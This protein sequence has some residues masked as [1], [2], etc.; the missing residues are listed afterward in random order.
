MPERQILRAAVEAALGE[1]LPPDVDE[2]EFLLS[3]QVCY[4]G[5]IA[6]KRCNYRAGPNRA[7]PEEDLLAIRSYRRGRGVAHRRRR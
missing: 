5:G 7:T 4:H 3:G 1:A 2:N 6:G